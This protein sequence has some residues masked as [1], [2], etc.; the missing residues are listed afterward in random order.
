M[1]FPLRSLTPSLSVLTQLN[2]HPITLPTT[3]TPSVMDLFISS[4]FRSLKTYVAIPEPIASSNDTPVIIA[5]GIT[6]SDNTPKLILNAPKDKA[7]VALAA[8]TAVVPL[9]YVKPLKN[10]VFLTL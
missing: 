7:S 6:P 10:L 4:T 1:P 2:A 5:S 9:I 3:L 8:I